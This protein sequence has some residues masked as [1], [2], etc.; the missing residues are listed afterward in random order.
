MHAR[1]SHTTCK[2]L[3][4][5][6]MH[7]SPHLAC[8]FPSPDALAQAFRAFIQ[9]TPNEHLTYNQEGASR[10]ECQQRQQVDELDGCFKTIGKLEQRLS[11]HRLSL[12]Q[13][14]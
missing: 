5:A 2:H 6:S 10:E 11:L 9:L 13:T 4:S 7:C 8:G 12:H 3:N 1:I 14:I